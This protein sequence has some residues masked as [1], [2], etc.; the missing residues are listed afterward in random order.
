MELLRGMAHGRLPFLS[1]QVIA[2]SGLFGCQRG[3]LNA[4]LGPWAGVR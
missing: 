3:F 2:S 4:P 1:A